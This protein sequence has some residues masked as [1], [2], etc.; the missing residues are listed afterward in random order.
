MIIDIVFTWVDHTDKEWM[1]KKKQDA[2]E[3]NAK[4]NVNNRYNS[5]L[6]EI[7]VYESKAS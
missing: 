6:N 5:N 4:H 7:T 3:C 2:I 1:K